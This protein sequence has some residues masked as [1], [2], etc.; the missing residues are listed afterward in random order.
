MHVYIGFYFNAVHS[1]IEVE[2]VVND[3]SIF[4]HNRELHKHKPKHIHKIYTKHSIA[5]ETCFEGG[6]FFFSLLS[7]SLVCYDIRNKN[8]T[9][10][11]K[12]W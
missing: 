2:H 9:T 5:E 11:E 1:S 4:L 6:Q 7:R 12:K 8:N 3:S 10:E